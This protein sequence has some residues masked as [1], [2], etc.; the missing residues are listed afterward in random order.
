D[1]GWSAMA[2]EGGHVTLSATTHAEAELIAG[3]SR[4]FGHCSAERLISG[5]GLVRIYTG[6]GGEA[7]APEKITELAF[8]GEATAAQ[9]MEIFCELLGT[10]ASNLA[11]TV[12]AHGGVYLAGGI[13]P[14]MTEV[15]ATSGFRKR[16]E[17]KARLG[18]YMAEIPTYVITAEYPSFLGLAGYMHRKPLAE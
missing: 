11:L 9:A 4:E 13:L 12:G 2:G 1:N 3:V 10:V 18:D 6:I 15:F 8:D 14:N 17:A 5:P 16:F 7:C